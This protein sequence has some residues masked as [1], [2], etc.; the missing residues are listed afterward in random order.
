MSGAAPNQ[1]GGRT[2]VPPLRSTYQTLPI[3]VAKSQLVVPAPGGD[4]GTEC[5]PICIVAFTENQ[6]VA[7]PVP[8]GVTAVIR[9]AEILNWTPD[10]CKNPATQ[11]RCDGI[12]TCSTAFAELVDSAVKN[13]RIVCSAALPCA[14]DIVPETGGGDGWLP[15]LLK[16]LEPEFGMLWLNSLS[17]MTSLAGGGETC[18]GI[19]KS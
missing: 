8:A 19:P 12:T 18:T 10:P 6:T 15:M 17:L 13:A 1:H 16:E 2:Q 9:N 14:A 11:S 3:S 5:P 7:L 4:I